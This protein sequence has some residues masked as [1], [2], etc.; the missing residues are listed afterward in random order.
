MVAF[1][2]GWKPIPPVRYRQALLRQISDPYYSLVA[3]CAVAVQPRRSKLKLL[4]KRTGGVVGAQPLG[5]I[6]EAWIREMLGSSA[7][8][9]S[10]SLTARQQ[11]FPFFEAIRAE[12]GLKRFFEDVRKRAALECGCDR[13]SA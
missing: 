4:E 12:D 9:P 10:L 2:D 7:F 11:E 3:A 8:D 1:E 6:A 5:E 13:A